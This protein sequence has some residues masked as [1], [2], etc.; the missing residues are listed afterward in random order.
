MHLK[1]LL[2][3]LSITAMLNFTACSAN[4]QTNPSAD[5]SAQTQSTPVPSTQS[6]SGPGQSAQEENTPGQSADEEPTPDGQQKSAANTP[7]LSV[8]SA[9]IQDLEQRIENASPDGS[10][11]EQKEQFLSLKN[12][13]DALDN[14]LEYMEDTL[15]SQYHDGSMDMSQYQEQEREIEALEDRLDHCEDQIEF[16]FRMDD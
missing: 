8:L 14:E 7:N 2:V 12:E 16:I 6:E 15:E 1:L 9:S 4:N 10:A 5:T 13:I 11:Q 3:I